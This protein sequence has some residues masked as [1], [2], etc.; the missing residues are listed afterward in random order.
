MGQWDSSVAIGICGMV[1]VVI[2]LCGIV[3]RLSGYR[4]MWDSGM[5]R[6]L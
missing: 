5:A 2:G 4:A 6:W 3:G 1:S